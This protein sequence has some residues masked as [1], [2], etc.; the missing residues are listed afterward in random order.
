MWLLLWLS[1][2][3]AKQSL[4]L[5]TCVAF[6]QFTCSVCQATAS[7]SPRVAAAAPLSFVCLALFFLLSTSILL[8]LHPL[9]CLLFSLLL[10]LYLESSKCTM[11]VTAVKSTAAGRSVKCL[12]CCP[13]AKMHKQLYT[14]VG[15]C[16]RQECD[17]T[18]LSPK[19]KVAKRDVH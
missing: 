19:S 10:L 14:H 9:L 6:H 18:R 4:D 7:K 5:Q 16:G 11:R 12:K 15:G 2:V 8:L 1:T 17:M 3:K 13:R